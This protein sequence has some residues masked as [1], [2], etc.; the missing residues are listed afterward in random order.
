V[1][2][3]CATGQKVQLWYSDHCV[4]AQCCSR[5]P[6]LSSLPAAGHYLFP[7]DRDKDLRQGSIAK[8]GTY[9]LVT[10]RQSRQRCSAQVQAS[11]CASR[12]STHRGDVEVIAPYCPGLPSYPDRS[13]AEAGEERHLGYSKRLRRGVSQTRPSLRRPQSATYVRRISL[14]GLVQTFE[15][16]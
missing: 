8:A 9:S 1:P 6:G 4:A 14:F 15:E 10:G 16:K 12:P 13:V 5:G 11:T 7:R 2:C 3:W